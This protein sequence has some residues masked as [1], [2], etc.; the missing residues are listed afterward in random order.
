MEID[1]VIVLA[2][3]LRSTERALR[4]AVK[5]Y[6]VD[7]CRENGEKVNS[8]LLCLKAVHRAF[9]YTV[10]TSA[11]GASELIQLVAQRL[12][13]SEAGYAERLHQIAA[14]FAAGLRQH[15]DLVWLRTTQHSLSGGTCGDTGQRAAPLLGLAIA[16][17]ARPV[18][19]Y[20]AFRPILAASTEKDRW[21]SRL[22]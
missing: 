21:A 11:L 9:F 7:R 20:R 2:E 19:V 15:E 16:G 10:P 12:P 1:P 17:A 4:D 13:V 8:I 3:E 5:S 6:E 22:H 14:R 18:V